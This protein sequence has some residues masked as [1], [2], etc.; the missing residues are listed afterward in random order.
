[1]KKCRQA[2]QTLFM[3]GGAVSEMEVIYKVGKCSSTEPSPQ[4]PVMTV[5]C[6]TQGRIHKR[7]LAYPMASLLQT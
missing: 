6:Q 1:M 2:A 3:E 4:H 5:F 7:H